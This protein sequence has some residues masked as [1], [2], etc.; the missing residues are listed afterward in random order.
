MP[1]SC[2]VVLARGSDSEGNPLFHNVATRS[3]V[4]HAAIPRSSMRR[5]WA[6]AYG[7]CEQKN[8]RQPRW[9][10]QDTRGGSTVLPGEHQI[11]R[12]L[13]DHGLCHCRS[14]MQLGRASAH[15]SISKEGLHRD[16]ALLHSGSVRTSASQSSHIHDGGCEGIGCLLRQVVPYATADK[17]VRVGSRE[18]LGVAAGPSPARTPKL[19]A[20]STGRRWTRC[21]TPLPRPASCA[22]L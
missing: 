15:P 2:A 5:I 12:D 16:Q 20:S 1:R 8:R 21:S 14:G 7:A 17:P 6:V 9:L 18:L 22:S 11:A 3:R 19:G 13:A 10:T 4:Q